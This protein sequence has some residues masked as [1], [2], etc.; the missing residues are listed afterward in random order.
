MNDEHLIPLLERYAAGHEPAL[1]DELF[2]R[3]MPLARAV[4]R[5]FSGRGV[6]TEDLEQVAGMALLKALERFEPARGFR[7]VTYAVPTITGDVRNY[8]RDKSGLMRMPRDMRQRLYQMT[9]EQERFEREHL[10]APTATELA[11]RMGIAPEEFLALLALRTQN[12]TVSLDTPVGEEG[13]TQLADLLGGADDRFERMERSEWAQWLLSKVGDTERELLTLR[14]R[15]G[16]GQRETAKR[17]GISQMQVSRLERRVL[18]R[19]RAMEA[20]A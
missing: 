10:R 8:L 19:L 18:S 16:L 3:Y 6:E 14:Y 13:D 7:F 20:Q 9:Q 15:D 11:Q 4:A 12:E 1:R 17:L 5:K 2:E